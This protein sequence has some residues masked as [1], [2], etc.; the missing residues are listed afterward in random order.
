MTHP[1]FDRAAAYRLRRAGLVRSPLPHRLPD[2][3]GR[4]AD[5][6]EMVERFNA[7]SDPGERAELFRE[8]AALRARLGLATAAAP[9]A[10]AVE[11]SLPPAA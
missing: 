5:L 3:E 8:I 11:T 6:A 7:S 2:A 10:P 9:R 1:T 4:K